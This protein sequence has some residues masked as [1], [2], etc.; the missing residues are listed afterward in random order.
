MVTLAPARRLYAA[1]WVKPSFCLTRPEFVIPLTSRRPTNY[2]LPTTR[3]P[4]MMAGRRGGA[5]GPP[6]VDARVFPSGVVDSA[7]HWLQRKGESR[8]GPEFCRAI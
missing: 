2:I 8:S 6:N 1:F 5:H 4:F 3:S 7:I